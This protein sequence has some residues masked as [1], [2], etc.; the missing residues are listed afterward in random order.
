MQA[1]RSKIIIKDRRKI[2]K[3]YIKA[4]LEAGTRLMLVRHFRNAPDDVYKWWLE[5]GVAYCCSRGQ[6]WWN[7]GPKTGTSKDKAVG[8]IY[9]R[10]CEIDLNLTLKGETYET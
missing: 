5:D 7:K 8:Y 2:T 3:S 9:G 1:K 6:G 10:R 4:E